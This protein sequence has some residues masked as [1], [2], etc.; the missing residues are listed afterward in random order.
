MV[1]DNIDKCVNPRQMTCDHQAKSLHY[2]HTYA[3]RDRIEVSHYSPEAK[4]P[5]TSTIHLDNLLPSTQDEEIIKHNFAILT[6]RVL[7]KHMSFFTKFGKGLDRH[8]RHEF[9]EEMSQKSDVVINIVYKKATYLFF[10]GP[11]WDLSERR[12]EV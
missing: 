7:M 2:F 4:I 9:S 12:A 10:I 8:I 6:A 5:D 11:P 1:G 3:V